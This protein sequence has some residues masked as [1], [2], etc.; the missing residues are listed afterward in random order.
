MNINY[1]FPF[2][3]SF[4]FCCISF[5]THNTRFTLVEY[6]L[7][8]SLG[9]ILLVTLSGIGS[10]NNIYFSLKLFYFFFLILFCLA[11]T[12]FAL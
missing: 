7:Y 6:S 11:G 3:F 12:L 1:A 10:G 5:G 2:V 8:H 4:L 9:L